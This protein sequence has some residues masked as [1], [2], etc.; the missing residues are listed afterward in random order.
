[1]RPSTRVGETANESKGYCFLCKNNIT[2]S[3][4]FTIFA[5]WFSRHST[6]TR[7]CK[8]IDWICTYSS[9][10]NGWKFRTTPQPKERKNLDSTN[11]MN[12]SHI[13]Y[14][15]S[16]DEYLLHEYLQQP[17]N[18][19]G[20]IISS[21]TENKPTMK[22]K[23]HKSD[24]SLWLHIITLLVKLQIQDLI[25]L[26]AQRGGSIPYGFGHWRKN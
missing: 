11:F 10:S 12:H 4:I 2:I 19:R 18:R 22:S 3:S 24:S 21:W 20:T 26:T 23:L 5:S 1:M 9:F 6:L 8:F 16:K 7:S 25:L 17:T 13:K 14:S 15:T